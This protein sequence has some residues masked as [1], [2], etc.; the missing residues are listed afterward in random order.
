MPLGD[1]FRTEPELLCPL[2]AGAIAEWEGFGGPGAFVLFRQ[3]ES[4]PS[5]V[6]LR[7]QVPD[8]SDIRLEDGRIPVFAHCLERHALMGEAVVVNG[9]FLGIELVDVDGGTPFPLSGGFVL[10]RPLGSRYSVSAL[11]PNASRGVIP[12]SITAIG[13]DATCILATRRRDTRDPSCVDEWYIVDV[14]SRVIEG[15]I[16]EPDVTARLDALGLVAPDVMQLPEDVG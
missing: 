6:R 5:E 9:V 11:S 7:S 14:K 1:F 12:A 4:R 15:P 2:C 10:W 8:G 3:G 16:P 13:Y